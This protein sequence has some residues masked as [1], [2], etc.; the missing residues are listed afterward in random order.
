MPVQLLFIL[1]TR[2][3]AQLTSSYYGKK[4]A[5]YSSLDALHLQCA[6]LIASIHASRRNAKPRERTDIKI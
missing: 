4:E 5:I 6:V 2:D 1:V 3:I